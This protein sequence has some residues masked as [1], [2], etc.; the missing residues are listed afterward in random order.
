MNRQLLYRLQ[1]KQII[2]VQVKNSHNMSSIWQINCCAVIFDDGIT[3]RTIFKINLPL[4]KI[5]RQLTYVI[6]EA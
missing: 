2:C 4:N 6:K 5:I 1:I 3:Y